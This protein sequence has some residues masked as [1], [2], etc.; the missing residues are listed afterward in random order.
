MNK[1]VG[2][3]MCVLMLIDAI[4]ATHYF[5]MWV[6]NGSNG[7]LLWVIMYSVLGCA[8]GALMFWTWV[9]DKGKQ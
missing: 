8:W 3:A 1:L 4:T 2:L 5:D 9:L 7:S 6:S